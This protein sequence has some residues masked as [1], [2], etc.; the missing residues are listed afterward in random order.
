[1]TV[2]R[3]FTASSLPLLA[4]VFVLAGVPAWAYVLPAVIASIE[5]AMLV[6]ARRIDT[7]AGF[8]AA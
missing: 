8:A 1:M 5:L 4:L 7:A 3:A 6:R 2:P